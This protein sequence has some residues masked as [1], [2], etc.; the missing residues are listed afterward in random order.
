M[1][2]LVANVSLIVHP[3]EICLVT[4]HLPGIP[5]FLLTL[6]L[7]NWNTQIPYGYEEL[8]IDVWSSQPSYIRITTKWEM[9][10]AQFCDLRGARDKYHDTKCHIGLIENRCP[11]NEPPVTAYSNYLP[12][13][14]ISLLNP[15]QP[16]ECKK[17]IKS[18]LVS[19]SPSFHFK[20]FWVNAQNEVKVHSKQFRY[21][22][23]Q[24]ILHHLLSSHEVIHHYTSL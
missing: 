17:S 3:E 6:S 18:C 5:A 1:L 21:P 22:L 4:N 19:N 8:Y 2:S 24:W 7:Q 23:L 10:L 20:V 13:V 15:N 12:T 16:N 14:L 11:E 9:G